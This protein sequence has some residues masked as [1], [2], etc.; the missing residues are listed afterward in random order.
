MR[1]QLFIGGIL[2]AAM[3]VGFFA[4]QLPILY[5]WGLPFAIGG[6]IMAIASFFLPESQG[7]VMPPEGYRFCVFC[8]TPV[9]LG[10]ERCPHCNGVQPR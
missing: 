1:S 10:A 6:A 9:P 8:S 3:G 2:V 4:L 7:P 5:F